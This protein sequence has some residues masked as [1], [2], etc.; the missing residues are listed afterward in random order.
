MIKKNK[1]TRIDRERIG[2]PG[3]IQFTGFDS[4]RRV[5]AQPALRLP[6]AHARSIS[7]RLGGPAPHSLVTPGMDLRSPVVKRNCE[8]YRERRNRLASKLTLDLPPSPSPGSTPFHPTL[9]PRHPT[10]KR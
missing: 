8:F 1:L 9:T 5:V 10:F 2:P 4:M 3:A 6:L 7:G